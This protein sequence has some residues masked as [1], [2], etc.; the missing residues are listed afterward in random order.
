M[1]GEYLFIL[2]ILMGSLKSSFIEELS[3]VKQEYIDSANSL[4]VESNDLLSNVV[5]KSMQPKIYLQFIKNHI[6]VWGIVIL[7]EFVCKTDGVGNIFSLAMKYN[8]LSLVIVMIVIII[9]TLF[10]MNMV[11]DT[12]KQKYFFW[13]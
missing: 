7:Y 2:I 11:M 13:D 9:I 12:I 8:D 1:W 5:W 6:S 3:S 4:G 10:I